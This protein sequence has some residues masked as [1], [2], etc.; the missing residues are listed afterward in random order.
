MARLD[1]SKQAALE[2]AVTALT[3]A[4]QK[5]SHYEADNESRK[6]LAQE[7]TAWILLADRLR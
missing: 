7:A 5:G 4:R 2:N 6:A 3:L 1:M